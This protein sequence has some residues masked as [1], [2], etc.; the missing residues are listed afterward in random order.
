MFR[1]GN[2]I[3]NTPSRTGTF[4][5]R[6]QSVNCT[7]KPNKPTSQFSLKPFRAPRR[8]EG[9]IRGLSSDLRTAWNGGKQ[10]IAIDDHHSNADERTSPGLYEKA[11]HSILTSNQQHIVTQVTTQDL[12]TQE[13]TEATHEM[14]P[15]R[16]DREDR[17]GLCVRSLLDQHMTHEN[18]TSKA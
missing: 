18:G 9:H 16:T 7:V 2:T 8:S 10:N 11:S 1:K 12:R 3:L 6:N 14:T 17:R 4:H 13:R 5:T 15:Q